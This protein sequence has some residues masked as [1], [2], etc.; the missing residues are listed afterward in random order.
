MVL[1]FEK[2]FGQRCLAVLSEVGSADA[3]SCRVG[4]GLGEDVRFLVGEGGDVHIGAAVQKTVVAFDT[5]PQTGLKI[6]H[7]RKRSQAQGFGL[8]EKIF[9]IG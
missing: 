6:E 1:G 3:T 5:F 7:R 8:T 2:F 9:S 4:H